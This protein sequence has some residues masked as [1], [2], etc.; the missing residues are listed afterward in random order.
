MDK[1]KKKKELELYEGPKANIHLDLQRKIKNTEAMM[2]YMD[3]GF[4]NSRPSTT[5]L[6]RNWGNAH[7]KYTRMDDRRENYPNREGIKKK[8]GIPI[9]YRPITCLP[10][11]WKILTTEI[12]DEIYFS[13]IW[14]VPFPEVCKQMTDVK[15]LLLYSNTWNHLTVCKKKC[16]QACLKFYQQNVY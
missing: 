16:A 15:L 2:A 13:N 5:Y 14:Y 12:R 10:E 8:G 11:M 6:S 7:N 4:K 9:N 1:K 3:S